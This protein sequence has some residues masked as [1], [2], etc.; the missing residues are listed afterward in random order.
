MTKHFFIL[1]ICLVVGCASPKNAIYM[2]EAFGTSEAQEIALLPVIDARID[3][4]V[5]VDVEKQI[6]KE[7]KEKLEKMDYDV[8]LA[9]TMGDVQDI[10]EEKLKSAS[11][12]WIRRLGPLEARWVMVLAL[13]D[14][15][16]KLTFGST[17]NAEITGYLFDK[18]SGKKLW[19]DKGIGQ[20]GQGGLLG[21]MMKGGMGDEAIEAAVKD[22]MRSIPK[23][24]AVTK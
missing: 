2:D 7:V 19:Q 1:C 4:T 22:L 23:R 12:Q 3:T 6:R 11:P 14:L 17:G 15:T 5:E 8:S 24:I 21:M 9:S 10:L 20:V 18:E 13:V 16:T